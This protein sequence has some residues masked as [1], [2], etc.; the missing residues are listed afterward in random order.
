MPQ[1]ILVIHQNYI[2]AVVS[3][4][5]CICIGYMVR[6]VYNIFM[7]RCV[8]LRRL[9]LECYDLVWLFQ[10]LI[11]VTMKTWHHLHQ[12]ALISNKA[13]S[14]LSMPISTTLYSNS[15]VKT[16]QQSHA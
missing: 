10:I 13:L 2:L 1:F 7:T 5:F 3:K 4:H 14:Q 15:D 11:Y 8:N 16:F 6:I 9:T 12:K